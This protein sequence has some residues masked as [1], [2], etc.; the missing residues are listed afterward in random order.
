VDYEPTAENMVANIAD[1]LLHNGLTGIDRIELWETPTS[2]AIW[3]NEE[4]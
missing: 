1:G 3:I 4:N 2:S